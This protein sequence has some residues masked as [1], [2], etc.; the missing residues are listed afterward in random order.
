L[1]PHIYGALNVEAIAHRAHAHVK[2]RRRFRA[3]SLP[4]A[5]RAERRLLADLARTTTATAA[6]D[7][8][9]EFARLEPFSKR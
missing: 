6:S 2:G 9:P 3:A 1:F 5:V 4:A 8:R 7:E